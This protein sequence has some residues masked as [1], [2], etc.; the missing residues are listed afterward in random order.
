MPWLLGLSA[1]QGL[2][3]GYAVK[4]TVL[5]ELDLLSHYPVTVD[6]PITP[7]S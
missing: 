5:K 1:L 3:S 7:N 2:R 6:G 4:V